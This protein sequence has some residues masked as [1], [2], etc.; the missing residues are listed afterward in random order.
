M[1]R[2]L[3]SAHPLRKLHVEPGLSGIVFG[4]IGGDERLHHPRFVNPWRADPARVAGA[5]FKD[6]LPSH[7]RGFRGFV[8]CVKGFW[9]SFALSRL[10]VWAKPV[11]KLLTRQ[12]RIPAGYSCSRLSP[13]DC[14]S[15]SRRGHSW[16][17]SGAVEDRRSARLTRHAPSR[18]LRGM[19]GAS[20]WP[21]EGMGAP[22]PAFSF[23]ALIVGSAANRGRAIAMR[24]FALCEGLGYATAHSSPRTRNRPNCARDARQRPGT[25]LFRRI[26]RTPQEPVVRG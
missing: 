22:E 15:A 13:A 25:L 16:A 20:H 11:L 1:S 17:A 14:R 19:P 26:P 2:A 7:V 10:E 6:D 24:A 4:V 3:P 23:G 5:D 9:H 18:T 8:P 21:R 12:G